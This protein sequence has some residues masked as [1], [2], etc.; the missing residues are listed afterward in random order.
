MQHDLF[1]PLSPP[2]M[3]EF[4]Q[5]AMAQGF[6]AV[7]GVDEAGRGPLAGPV[8]AA[9]VILS[10][11]LDIPGINDSKKLSPAVRERLYGE[12]MNGA[13][14][15]G[16]GLSDNGTIDRIN[17][18]QATLRAMEAA[19]GKLQISPDYLLI[20]GISRT[21]L[22]LPQRTVKKGDSLSISIA[23][24]SIIAKVTR[25]R[26]MRDYDGLYPGYGFAD[27]KGY[28]SASHLAAIAS[29]GPCP[30]HRLTFRGVRE[31]VAFTGETSGLAA[32]L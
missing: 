15:V 20:D 32:K 2:T 30:I 6:R 29:L 19:V 1:G 23:A 22:S 17:I 7:A 14:A 11:D 28:G 24:A 3:W 16:V 8:V 18:L 31:H 10:P 4:E 25:D 12:I 5:I 13:V 27:H 26:L 9:A 21:A